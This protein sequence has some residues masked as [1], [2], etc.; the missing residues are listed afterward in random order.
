MEPRSAISLKGLNIS[1]CLVLIMW[2]QS[3]GTLQTAGPCSLIGNLPGAI[4]QWQTR[5][6]ATN[7]WSNGCD[8]YYHLYFSTFKAHPFSQRIMGTVA[9]PSQSYSSQQNIK[10]YSVQN[11]WLMF[12]KH[13]NQPMQP[14]ACLL[15]SKI[16]WMQWFVLEIQQQGVKGKHT[17]SRA[18][19][20]LQ[21]F[22]TE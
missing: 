10:H 22:V 19:E 17:V 13:S 8:S 5:V 21:E 16:R 4:C 6:E 3:G 18:N 1:I 9:F 7:S 20:K 11:S 14:S 15:R 2:V 12:L